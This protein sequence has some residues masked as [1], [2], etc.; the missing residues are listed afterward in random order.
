MVYSDQHTGSTVIGLYNLRDA[1][2]FFRKT[3]F[4]HEKKRFS[5]SHLFDF[6]TE[7]YAFL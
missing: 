4:S 3:I 6:L 2:P 7:K 1:A 5:D